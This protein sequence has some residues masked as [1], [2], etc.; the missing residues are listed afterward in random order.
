[1][2]IIELWSFVA[3][4]CCVLVSLVFDLSVPATNLLI[5]LPL[6]VLLSAVFGIGLLTWR[7][8]EHA[9]E[10]WAENV[11][12][13]GLE[14]AGFGWFADTGTIRGLGAGKSIF[15]AIMLTG[16]VVQAFSHWT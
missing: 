7:N 9:A 13:R 3:I 14:E 15:T 10:I 6:V 5:V 8:H 4:V 12:G 11:R 16:L 2:Q 1:M